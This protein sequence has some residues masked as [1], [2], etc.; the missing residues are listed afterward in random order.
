M[1]QYNK[2]RPTTH[3][4]YDVAKG[5]MFDT[6]PLNVFGYNQTIG[7]VFETVW[8]DGGSYVYP[9]SAL[10]MD[11]VST[12]ASDTMDLFIDGL[13]INYNQ[14]TETVTLTG[15]SAVTT[16]TAFY[17]INRA[18]ILAGSNVGN[19]SISNGGTNYAFI[20]AGIG[21]TQACIYTVPAGHSAYFVRFDIISATA[22]QNKYVTFRNVLT[23]N[24]GRILR[25][26][27]GTM[28]IN[29]VSLDRQVPFKI[30]EKTDFHFEAKSS[31]SENEVG[32]IVEGIL[33]KD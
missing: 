15:T 4:F 30:A 9:T 2:T 23:T 1:Y 20:G 6:S 29:Q 16:T 24:T 5:N 17:R 8:D 31:Q 14:I 25:V 10:I 22:N 3:F 11:V 33:T 21:S 18:T 12:S 28:A 13:D 27:E 32:I 19:I 26:G 7:T